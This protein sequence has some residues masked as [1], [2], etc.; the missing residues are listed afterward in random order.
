MNEVSFGKWLKRRRKAA[1]LTQEQLAEQISCSTSALRKMEAEERRPSEQTV[2]QLAEVFNIPI[3]ERATF[4]KFARG[5]WAAA[6]AGDREDAPWRSSHSPEDRSPAKLHLATFLFTDIQDSTKLWENATQ[7]MKVALARHHAILQETIDAKGGEVFQIV[8]DAFCAVFP[9]PIS[10][11]SAAVIAQH[12]LYHES[13]DLPFPIRVRM[14][15][16]TGEAEPSVS[17]GGYA[18]NPTLNRV[19]RI[20][21]AA[22]GGQVLLSLATKVLIENSLPGDAELRDMGEYALKNLNQAEHLFQLSIAGLPSSFPPLNALTHRNNLPLP[23]TSFIGRDKEISEVVHLLETSRLVTLIGPGGTG[24]TRLAIEVGNKLLGHYPDGIWL[25]EL[26]PILDEQLVPSITAMALGL[27]EEPRRPVMELLCDYLRDKQL[28]LILD[29]CEHMVHACAQLV[30]RLLQADPQ[31]RIVATS[32]ELLGTAGESAYLVP[33]LN[34]PDQQDALTAE[35]IGHYEAG[36]LFIERASAKTQRFTVSDENAISI[37]QICRRLDGIPLAIELAAGKIRSLSVVQI[38]QRLNDRFHLLTGGSRTSLP[39]HQTLRAAMEWSYNLLSPGEQRLFRSLS[40][41]VGGWTLEAAEAVCSDTELTTQPPLKKEDILELLNQLVNKS[42][43]MTEERNS[44]IRYYL[45]ETIRQ[46]AADLMTIS[47][48]SDD[49]RNRHLDYFL[50]FAEGAAP[51]LTGP[52][53]LD[54][55]NRLEIDHNNLRSALEYALQSSTPESAVRIVAALGQFWWVRN[56]FKEGQEWIRQVIGKGK[57]NEAHAMALHWGGALARTRGQF[58]TAR[59]LALE[60]LAICRGLE[61]AAGIARALNAVAA[62]DY[63]ENK[64]APAQELW[65]EALAIYRELGDKRGM[66]FV[67]NN[68]GYL[69]L[70]E[71]NIERAR[72]INE[73][74]ASYCR[75]LG[76][77]WGLS[78]VLLNLGH[79]F[80][81]QENMRTARELYEEDLALGVELGDTD[82][83]A[84]ALISLANVVCGE[85]QYIRSAQVH[86]AAATVFKESEIYLEPVEQAYY[87]KT[88]TALKNELDQE[89]YER[90]LEVGKQ[91]SLEQ[92][93]ELALKKE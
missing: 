52:D 44:Q 67:L 89:I 61:D 1:G 18:S 26:A 42:L 27:R 34:M 4:L 32:R 51:H 65:N 90:E 84:Y 64:Y 62:I 6:P 53:Q 47:H 40:V 14:G 83:I 24:K 55:F 49:M 20:L 72:A 21:K 13:W 41:F 70:T 9:S 19:A 39:R 81:A 79:A 50:E 35:I 93:I 3:E 31:I 54:W 58:E 60:S 87:E 86:G 29:N 91:L 77:K 43:V 46:Y 74:C 68:V 92:A 22:H 85:G 37:A 78:R 75:E 59:Q 25:V 56:Y 16:H 2:E 66:V 71:E 63:F 17:S 30:D 73:E 15:I 82:C 7:K 76:D 33:S 5:N 80:Y 23:L 36:R 48:E 12:K 11:I 88:I 57:H 69:A 45:L 10:A 38:A 28:L 8:G